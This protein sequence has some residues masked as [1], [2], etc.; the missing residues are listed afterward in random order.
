MKL[1]FV[2]TLLTLGFESLQSAE[3]AAVPS[4]APNDKTLDAGEVG[5]VFQVKLNGNM[6]MKFSYCPPGSFAMGSPANED[7][8]MND[9]DQVQVSISKGFW[10]GQT[11]VT[12]GEWQELMDTTLAQ[13]AEKANDAGVLNG[14][15]DDH[16]MYFVSWNDAQKFIIRL[17]GVA[18]LPSGWKFALP[19][20]AQ[21]EYAC[22]A[23]T[24]STFCFGDTLTS[25]QAN[26]DPRNVVGTEAL[27][28]WAL[29]KACAVRSYP[30]NNWGIYDMHG[31]VHEWCEDVR[32]NKL[33]G[34]TD[35]VGKGEWLYRVYRG[36]SW[37][38]HAVTCRSARR[39]ADEAMY[40]RALIGFRVTIVQG[41]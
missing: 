32:T 3:P 5:K 20:E 26:I 38:G 33:I 31:N 25:L 22:R 8:R 28:K 30:A 39:Y 6:F 36:G 19:T 16:P 15:G 14:I 37:A 35:P 23:G 18:G 7:G 34:G 10:M 41:K 29:G 27:K 4:E 24:K 11:E 21:W 9:E 13:Q 17:S 12:Q 40:W 2:I 1:V